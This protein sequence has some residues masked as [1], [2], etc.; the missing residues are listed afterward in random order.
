MGTQAYFN[1]ARK[2]PPG[3]D[4]TYNEIASR[5]EKGHQNYQFHH[6]SFF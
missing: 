5:Y 2:G 3:G 1:V 4:G 6:S